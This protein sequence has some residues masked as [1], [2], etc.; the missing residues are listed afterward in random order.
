MSHASTSPRPPSSSR[1]SD[2]ASSA[3]LSDMPDRR[4]S[5]KTDSQWLRLAL[6]ATG[7]G[8]SL[9]VASAAA[10]KSS[11]VVY[12]GASLA[13]VGLYIACA[14]LVLPLPLP[15][16]LSERRNRAFRR[17]VGAF[18]VE[19]HE[20]RARPVADEA[21]LVS[22]EAACRDWSLRVQFWLDENARPADAA[23]FE[24]AI[25]PSQEILGSFDHA[26]NALRLK[27]SWQLNVLRELPREP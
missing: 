8:V 1:T 2:T 13:F 19:G 23:A 5:W 4:R 26:H 14:V 7:L 21:E 15:P 3:I 10:W 25:G 11:P 17:H 27:L 9:I 18:L 24:H 22:I 20:L 12:V 6:T 16:L